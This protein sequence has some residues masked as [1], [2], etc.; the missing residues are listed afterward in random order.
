LIENGQRQ[1]RGSSRR[2]TASPRR[3]RGRIRAS[4]VVKADDCIRRGAN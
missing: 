4:A 1:R 3:R 2:H